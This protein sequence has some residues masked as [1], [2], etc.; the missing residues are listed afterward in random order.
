MSERRKITKPSEP[1][2]AVYGYIVET[3]SY[4]NLSEGDR[5]KIIDTS[6]NAHKDLTGVQ[7]EF[8]AFKTNILSG[9]QWVELWG[10]TRNRAGWHVTR[11]TNIVKVDKARNIV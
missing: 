11:I 4:G 1:T 5:V 8:V 7:L 2:D 6:S 3:R 10:G 9:F